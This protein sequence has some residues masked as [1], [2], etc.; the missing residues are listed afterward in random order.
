MGYG[1]QVAKGSF[2]VCGWQR[3]LIPTTEESLLQFPQTKKKEKMTQ[4]SHE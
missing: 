1:E 3:L 2:L 4:R